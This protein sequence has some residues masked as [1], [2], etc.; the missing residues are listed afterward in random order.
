MKNQKEF[1]K[2]Y[3][4]L[5]NKDCRVYSFWHCQF[6]DYDVPH[7]WIASD[8]VELYLVEST[9]SLI[10]RWDRGIYEYMWRLEPNET[11]LKFLFDRV[12]WPYVVD[13]FSYGKD[14]MFDQFNAKESINRMKQAVLTDRKE[15]TIDSVR[16]R[17]LYDLIDSMDS[18]T[19]DG[20][21]FYYD[22]EEE[23]KDYFKD[24]DYGHGYFLTRGYSDA[25]V[26]L[27]DTVLPTIG[28]WFK[29]NINLE[30]GELYE[31]KDI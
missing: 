4:I 29:E 25:A 15:Q 3:K 26:L 17:E 21:G 2:Y 13:K 7:S 28:K 24:Y 16:A 19:T 10:F 8:Y 31:C 6:G 14:P 11:L 18:C 27:K 12:N 22:M 20:T 5:G 23:L 9:G 1:F 30:T